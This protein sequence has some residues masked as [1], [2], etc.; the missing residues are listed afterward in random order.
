M[1]HT[2][3]HNHEHF[4]ETKMMAH[5]HGHFVFYDNTNKMTMRVRLLNFV[6]VRLLNT[7]YN[8]NKNVSL[9]N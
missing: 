6:R 3:A 4:C 9:C 1:Q 2:L 7:Y 5:Y 8:T